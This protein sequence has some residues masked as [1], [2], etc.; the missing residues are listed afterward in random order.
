M[1]DRETVLERRPHGNG[2]ELVVTL[3]CAFCGADLRGRQLCSHLLQCPDAD[4]EVRCN[5][6]AADG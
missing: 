2:G 5:G 4:R 3:E 6:V 1:S